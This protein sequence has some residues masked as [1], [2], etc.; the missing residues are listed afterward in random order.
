MEYIAQSQREGLADMLAKAKFFSIQ[1]DGSTD[2]ANIEDEL[3]LT[4]YFDA[5]TQDGRVPV[6]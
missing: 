3:F 4:L 2:S 6:Q 1:A 5:H